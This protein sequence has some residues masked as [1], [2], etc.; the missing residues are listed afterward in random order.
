[1]PNNPGKPAL[2]KRGEPDDNDPATK[3][4]RKLGLRPA[5]WPR[6]RRSKD[7]PTNLEILKADLLRQVPVA[8]DG[9]KMKASPYEVMIALITNKPL[10]GTIAEL[11]ALT[12]VLEELHPSPSPTLENLVHYELSDFLD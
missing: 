4:F 12:E 5:S 11:L 10:N 3:E 7:N 8:S 2:A 6:R 9:R 1:M